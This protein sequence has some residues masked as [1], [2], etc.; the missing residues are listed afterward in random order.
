LPEGG[1]RKHREKI[2][3]E[4]KLADQKN[5][6]FT[7]SKPKQGGK[8]VWFRCAECNYIFSASKNTVLVICRECKKLTK[9]EKMDNEWMAC[10]DSHS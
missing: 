5:L 4:S 7:F 1:E 6:P 2:H 3:R 8:Q 10:M 9:V